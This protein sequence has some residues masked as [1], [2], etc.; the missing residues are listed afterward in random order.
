MDDGQAAKYHPDNDHKAVMI[1]LYS[2]I[3]NATVGRRLEII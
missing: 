2:G 3:H 1:H